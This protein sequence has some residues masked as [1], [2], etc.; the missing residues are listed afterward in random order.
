MKKVK[1]PCK[2]MN[3]LYFGGNDNRVKKHILKTVDYI[4]VKAKKKWSF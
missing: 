4:W 1:R 2:K 3:S